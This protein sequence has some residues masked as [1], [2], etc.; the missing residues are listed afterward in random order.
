V[1]TK[2]LS[3]EVLSM[4]TL[5]V[6]TESGTGYCAK[7]FQA[8]YACINNKGSRNAFGSSDMLVRYYSGYYCQ[9][10]LRWDTPTSR[11]LESQSVESIK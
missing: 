2:V 6:G 9:R 3:M 10:N 4:E 7:S 11:K 1:E 5:R 8:Y